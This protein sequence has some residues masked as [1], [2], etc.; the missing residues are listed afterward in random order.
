LII[1]DI[2]GCYE[3]LQ[4]LLDKASLCKD[5]EII[6]IGD[7]VDR[8]PDTP[9]VLE[10]FHTNSNARSI[11]GNHER[12]HVRS[13]RG[14]IPLSLSQVISRIQ[15][16]NAYE[17]AIGYMASLP[18]FLELPEAILVHGYLEPSVPLDKQREQVLAGTLSG[19]HYL[20]TR[21]DN[22]P[23]YERYDGEKPVIVGHH[24]YLGNHAPLIY[25]DKVYGIDTDCC[26]GGALTGLLL[27]NFKLFSI[28]SSK[29]HW[30]CVRS[31]HTTQAATSSMN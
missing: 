24:H 26:R 1:G 14:E 19:A 27:P 9:K 3:E 2:H 12:K 25:K 6:A 20:A 10:F 18:Y 15:L 29:N 31:A 7:I 16:G 11:M 21:Y 30:E 5:D 8:G 22:R 4:Q 23:W 28:L 17:Q 13:H